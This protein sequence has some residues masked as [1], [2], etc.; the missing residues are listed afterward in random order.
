ME[1]ESKFN[2]KHVY[3]S[4]ACACQRIK[5]TF[6][7]FIVNFSYFVT[8]INQC[9]NCFMICFYEIVDYCHC[10]NVL[11]IPFGTTETMYLRYG[12]I[13]GWF[14]K[15]FQKVSERIP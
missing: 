1:V 13:S 10:T 2:F 12:N 8:V 7:C 3:D 4:D 9:L 15:D 11:L 6:D 5:K 14:S